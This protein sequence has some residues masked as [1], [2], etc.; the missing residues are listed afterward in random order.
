MTSRRNFLATVG[1][2]TV[3]AGCSSTQEVP[4]SGDTPTDSGGENQS[5]N[6]TSAT[7]ETTA[8]QPQDANIEPSILFDSV[9]WIDE[10]G[11][12]ELIVTNQDDV[13]VR[14]LKIIVDWYD[15]NGNFVD[16][17]SRRV[18][19][20]GAGKS[21]YLFIEKSTDYLA[22]S[23]EFT[24]RGIRQERDIPDDLTIQSVEVNST[25]DIQGIL[26]NDR[27]SEV[28]VSM[29]ATVYDN[30]WLTNTGATTQTRI[31]SG[32]DWRFGFPTQFVDADT[33]A[34]G[35]EIELFVTSL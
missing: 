18:P 13:A 10:G 17:D 28:A 21:W 20:L 5:T 35:D 32:A 19:A 23:F 26:S 6:G 16:W 11:I 29:L 27:S 24:A 14:Q 22:D 25:G 4:N 7:N 1:T 30:G 2:A 3:L 33:T 9:E 15:E 31:P 12:V 8:D 34:P